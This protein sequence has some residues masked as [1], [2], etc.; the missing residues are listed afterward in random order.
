[1]KTT[2]ELH[3]I[4]R[5]KYFIEEQPKERRRRR[6]RNSLEKLHVVKVC[7]KNW[8]KSK[9][10]FYNMDEIN[11]IHFKGRCNVESDATPNSVLSSETHN[12]LKQL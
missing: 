7:L 2:L 9:G 1:M 5:V 6:E 4:V 11:K 12:V 3:Y 10:V 8:R